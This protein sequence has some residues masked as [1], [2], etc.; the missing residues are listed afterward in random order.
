[1]PDIRGLYPVPEKC[2]WELRALLSKSPKNPKNQDPKGSLDIVCTPAWD[3]HALC[4][5]KSGSEV[6][7]A[8]MKFH[9]YGTNAG[10]SY[11]ACPG[12]QPVHMLSSCGQRNVDCMLS[13]P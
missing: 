7:A 2:P 1:M 3:E 4:L 12:G 9:V 5:F 10:F 8:R 11:A 13:Q 6:K